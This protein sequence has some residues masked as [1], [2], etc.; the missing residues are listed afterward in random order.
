MNK[1]ISEKLV[2]FMNFAERR[3]ADPHQKEDF[4]IHGILQLYPDIEVEEV[5]GLI[6]LLIGVSKLSTK[7]V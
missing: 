5:K 1:E 2:S 3:Y 4:V 6:T 7:I